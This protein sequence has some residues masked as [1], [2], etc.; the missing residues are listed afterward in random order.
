MV[1]HDINLVVSGKFYHTF[2]PGH[3]VL[4]DS[5]CIFHCR[6]SCDCGLKYWMLLNIITA[7]C[8]TPS[9]H[10]FNIAKLLCFSIFASTWAEY[11]LYMH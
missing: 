3:K 2:R 10:C 1:L 7:N 4:S 9:P 11:P 5:V 6:I 8:S